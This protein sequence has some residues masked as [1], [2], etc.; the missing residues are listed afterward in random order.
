MEESRK[1]N[2]YGADER[3][4]R[5]AALLGGMERRRIFTIRRHIWSAPAR[6]R[7]DLLF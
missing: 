5:D 1:A 7:F 4:L 6:R 3:G 2:G